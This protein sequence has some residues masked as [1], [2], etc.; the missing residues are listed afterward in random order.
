MYVSY[1]FGVYPSN[2]FKVLSVHTKHL[3]NPKYIGIDKKVEGRFYIIGNRARSWRQINPI[4]PYDVGDLVLS[5]LFRQ[6]ICVGGIIHWMLPS[7]RT[8]LTFCLRDEKFGLMPLPEDFIPQDSA[9]IRTR[10][11]ILVGGRLTITL[12]GQR[13][14]PMVKNL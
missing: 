6:G 7:E 11:V 8:M 13:I 3:I 12:Q 10:G 5:I 2:K 14:N 9:D 1:S 4:W